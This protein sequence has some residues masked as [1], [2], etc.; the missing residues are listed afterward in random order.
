V[1]ADA[2]VCETSVIQGQVTI[3]SK[4]IVHPRAIYRARWTNI[5]WKRLP[6]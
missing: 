1:A 2:L 3:G 6:D 5:Y 4:T